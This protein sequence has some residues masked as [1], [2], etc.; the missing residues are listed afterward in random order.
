[1]L[2]GGLLRKAIFIKSVVP[3]SELN[4]FMHLYDFVFTIFLC[5]FNE[6]EYLPTG[7]INAEHLCVSLHCHSFM[8]EIA[9]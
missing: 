9:L 2:P 3:V 7:Q 5:F 1:M 8:S 4:G 6:I